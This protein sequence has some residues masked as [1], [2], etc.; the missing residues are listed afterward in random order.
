MSKSKKAEEKE[1]RELGKAGSSAATKLA[2]TKNTIRTVN[3]LGM[4]VLVKICE[5]D[6]VTEGGL[7]IPE[8][9]KKNMAESLIAEV[10]E[11]ASALDSDTHEET[12]VSGIPL[13]AQVL[14]GKEAGTVVPWDDSLR[15]VETK[16]VLAIVDEVAI[17]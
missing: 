12:N 4:R 14:I 9:A 2:E 6:D 17:T 5:R 1:M 10:L 8:N 7:Y 3:P 16:E 15:I 11:V 13:G